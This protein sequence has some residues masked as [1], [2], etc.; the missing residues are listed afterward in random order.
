MKHGIFI[1]QSK[2]V[3]ERL[4]FFGMEDSKLG[5]TPMVT[6]HKISKNDDSTEVNQTLYKS[7]IGKLKYVV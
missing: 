5:I 6:G 4:K 2:Y 1:T 7:M 3:K